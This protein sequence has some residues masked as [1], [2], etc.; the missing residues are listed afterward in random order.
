MKNKVTTYILYAVGE[1]TLVVVGI[2]IA[3]SIDNWNQS[4]NDRKKELSYLISYAGDLEKN[5][6]ELERVIGK[7]GMMHLIADTLIQRFSRGQS[8]RQP[9]L[10]S[11][12]FR[13]A[14]YT[15]YLSQEGTTENL[16]GASSLEIIQNLLIRTSFVTQEADQKRIREL[17]KG[18]YGIFNEYLQFLKTH[19]KLYNYSNGRVVI[20]ASTQSRLMKDDHFLNMLDDLSFRYKELQDRYQTRKEEL[21][22]LLTV[23]KAE[24]D[25]LKS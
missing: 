17:E 24:I 3:V 12:A 9:E 22:E 20:N 16:L 21:E 23:V 1:I 19:T 6:G 11:M 8:I 5:I 10:D 13:L 25:K 18:V 15:L 7:S 2:L 4:K 14:E